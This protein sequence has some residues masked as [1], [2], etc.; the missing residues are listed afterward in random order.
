MSGHACIQSAKNTLRKSI[1]SKLGLLE[2]KD[3]LLQSENVFKKLQQL[4]VYKNSK[5]V[6]IYL[7]TSNEIDTEPIIQDMFKNNKK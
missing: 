5:R 1:K 7:S 2:E 4:P 3:K 6:S